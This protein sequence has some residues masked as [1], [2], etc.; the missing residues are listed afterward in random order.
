MT[1]IKDDQ[2]ESKDTK[3][4][5]NAS[6]QIESPLA[7]YKVASSVLRNGTNDTSAITLNALNLDSIAN[8]YARKVLPTRS[9][10]EII[11]GMTDYGIP[12]QT[13]E[14]V[15]QEIA[16]FKESPAEVSVNLMRNNRVV[17][18]GESHGTPN[19]QRELGKEILPELARNGATHFAI[20]ASSKLQDDLNRYMETG[21]I[22][23]NKLPVRLR[24]EDYLSMLESVRKAGLKI[25]AVD[26]KNGD[27]NEHMAKTISTIL[28]ENA[29]NKVVFWVGSQHLNRSAEEGKKTAGDHLRE[30]FSVAVAR[31]VEQNERGSDTYPLADLTTNIKEPT[32]IST[33][34]AETLGS[35]PQSKY[36]D[37]DPER[38]KDWDYV[39][40]YPTR[41]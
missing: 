4:Q 32:A 6:L 2:Q 26:T 5:G 41:K 21:E 39:F 33:K 25:I 22:D 34:S 14:R 24:H 29:D 23:I 36:S 38:M 13:F 19:F 37:I 35:L 15:L 1:E 8:E 40:V 20:E 18:F 12:P 30:R 27:R 28:D 10:S 9:D 17:G 16:D 3:Q 7:D 11:A 31:P